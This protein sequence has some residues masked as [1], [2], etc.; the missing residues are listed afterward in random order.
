MQLLWSSIIF[1]GV[2]ANVYAVGMGTVTINVRWQV[3]LVVC[4]I[5]VAL[6]AFA[7][8][9]F[10]LAPVLDQHFPAQPSP[11]FINI[12]LAGLAVFLYGT[13]GLGLW[14]AWRRWMKWEVGMVT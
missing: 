3:P 6:F 4:A 2:V 1:T 7:G 14:L 12:M 10:L 5:P 9:L 11:A 13:A 8:V